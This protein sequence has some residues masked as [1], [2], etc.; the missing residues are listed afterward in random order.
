MFPKFQSKF[1]PKF[2]LF[3]TSLLV[4]MSII[5]LLHCYIVTSLP[6]VYH[7]SLL[8]CCYSVTLFFSCY[9]YH[10]VT[11][12]QLPVYIYINLFLTLFPYVEIIVKLSTTTS[13]TILQYP[14]KKS[15]QQ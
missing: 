9:L 3:V 15:R 6:V 5:A 13:S 7:A 8:L 12:T 11:Y 14:P 1:K 10:V 2:M 4:N